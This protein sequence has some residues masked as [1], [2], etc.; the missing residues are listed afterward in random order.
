VHKASPALFE[1]CKWFQ[2]AVASLP[3]S[4]L[5]GLLAA[6]E[7]ARLKIFRAALTNRKPVVLGAHLHL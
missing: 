5:P 4:A 1:A 2:G 7:N 3:H 6:Q